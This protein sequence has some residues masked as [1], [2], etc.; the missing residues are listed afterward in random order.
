MPQQA[1]GQTD[2]VRDKLRAIG[3]PYEAGSLDSVIWLNGYL[4]GAAQGALV[5]LTGVMPSFMPQP[6]L[7]PQGRC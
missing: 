2:I 6:E 3:C 4:A 5:A 1:I 7:E